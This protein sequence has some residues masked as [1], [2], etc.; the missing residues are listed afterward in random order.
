[1]LR[2]ARPTAINLRW[3]VDRLMA[4]YHAIGALSPDGE[5]IAA[6][7]HDEAMAIV[8]EATDDHG[9]LAEA[10]LAILPATRDRPLQ[11]P[12]PLQHRSAGVRPVRD[13][14]RRRAGRAPGGAAAARLGGRDP[15]V[16]AGRPPH[17]VGAAAGGR[18]AHAPAGHGGRAAHGR[19]RGR[20]DPRRRGSGRGQ[21]RHREQA[22]DVHAGRPRGAPRRA[23]PRLRPALVGRPR[24]LPTARR[25]RS[26]TGPPSRSARSAACGSRPRAPRSA[27]P[28]ST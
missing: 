1:M 8:A 19:W 27:T 7:L 14:A 12:D 10:G 11:R 3:A 13:G 17:R 28:R 6:A 18:A 2:A 26:R 9:R 4:R 23:V 16:P 25:S 24:R 21:R 15:A 22:R 5:A 20:R